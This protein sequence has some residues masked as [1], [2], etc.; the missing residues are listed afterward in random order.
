MV[1]IKVR[2]NGPYRVSGEN[3][4]VLDESGNLYQLQE[5]SFVLCRCGA[6][7][8]KPFCDGS[9]RRIK[10]VATEDAPHSDSS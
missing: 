8:T 3:I 2:Q 10:F 1:T 7:T 5:G 9:H 4:V 6:S